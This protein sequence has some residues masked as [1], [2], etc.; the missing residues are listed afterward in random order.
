MH[1]PQN[2]KIDHKTQWTVGNHEDGYL[3]GINN[4]IELF[5]DLQNDLNQ[6]DNENNDINNIATENALVDGIEKLSSDNFK[7]QQTT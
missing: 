3:I 5:E 2:V 6:P 7:H 4:L 1:L